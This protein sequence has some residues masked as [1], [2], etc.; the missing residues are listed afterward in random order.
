MIPSPSVSLDFSREGKLM[1]G[2][3]VGWG[4]DKSHKP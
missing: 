1:R 3:I 2:G 4:E